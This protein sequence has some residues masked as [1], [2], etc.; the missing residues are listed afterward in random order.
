MTNTLEFVFDPEVFGMFFATKNTLQQASER[1]YIPFSIAE[2][3]DEAATGLS[4]R[5]T[6]KIVECGIGLFDPQLFVQQQ[7]W[8]P[9]GRDD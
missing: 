5:N 2:I 9:D 3:V 8:L 7:Q 6:E 1:R 4:G